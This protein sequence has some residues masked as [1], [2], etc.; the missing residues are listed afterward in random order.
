MTLE[1]YKEELKTLMNEVWEGLGKLGEKLVR[2]RKDLSAD[3]YD[4][5]RTWLRTWWTEADLNAA[6]AVG[7]GDLNVHLF[8]HGTRSSKV[9]SLSREDQQ[10][11][12]SEEE[13][14]VYDNFGRTGRKTWANMS[15]DER[16][17][18]LG[19]KG[20][21]IHPLSKQRQPGTKTTKTTNYESASFH[22]RDLLLNGGARQGSIQIGTIIATMPEDELAEFYREIGDALAGKE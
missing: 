9:W 10:R 7:R 19:D 8:P 1:T 12:L 4:E 17:R 21:F 22:Q 5:L 16:N 2:A 13:F 11:L 20:G 3:D 15:P 14:P 18:L 6:E